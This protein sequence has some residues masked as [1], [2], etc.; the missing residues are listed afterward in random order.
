MEMSLEPPPPAEMPDLG[1]LSEASAFG[2]QSLTEESPE[3]NPPP[4]SFED[5]LSRASGET[6]AAEIP[7]MPYGAGPERESFGIDAPVAHS[8]PML[9]EESPEAPPEDEEEPVA[10]TMMFRMPVQLAEPVLADD[11]AATPPQVEELPLATEPPA[12][13]APPESYPSAGAE[14][15]E[16]SSPLPPPE[17][18]PPAPIEEEPAPESVAPESEAPPAAAEEAAQGAAAVVDTELVHWIVHNVVVRMA[19]PALSTAQVEELIRQITD[20]MINDL[21]QPPPEA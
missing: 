3:M 5:A 10:R 18:L 2:D 13:A 9:V 15:G 14:S 6:P 11:S 1:A 7:P 19:P 21:T 17:S 16:I 4:V 20:E 8:E 12:E